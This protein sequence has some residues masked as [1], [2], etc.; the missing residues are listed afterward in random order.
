[1]SNLIYFKRVCFVLG[2]F[3]F[4]FFIAN[5]Q[6][7]ISNNFNAEV[8][9]FANTQQA[10]DLFGS[11]VD[12]SQGNTIVGSRWASAGIASSAGAA[13]IFSQD[14]NGRYKEDARLQPQDIS[15][16]D[17]FGSAVAISGD[18]AVVG[19]YGHDGVFG[20]LKLEDSGA[21]Y[22]YRL[23]ANGNWVLEAK[24]EPQD[25]SAGLGFG[26]AVALEDT[27]QGTTLVIGAAGA[28]GNNTGAFYVYEYDRGAWLEGTRVTPP[29]AQAGDE[30]GSA[31]AISGDALLVA[32]AGADATGT[33]YIY[34]RHKNRNNQGWQV[35]AAL[36]AGDRASRTFFGYSVALDGD[37]ALIGA[38][39][40]DSVA[41]DAGATFVFERQASG[42]WKA[43]GKLLAPDGS[44]DDKFGGAIALENGVAVI[45]A[46]QHDSLATN[47]GAVY[48][49]TRMAEAN[50]QLQ[51][52]VVAVDSRRS[53]HFGS[54][55]A[56]ENGKLAVGAARD[57]DLAETSGSAYVYDVTQGISGQTIQRIADNTYEQP[58]LNSANT[59]S[60]LNTAGF[61]LGNFFSGLRNSDNN[62][63]DGF[64]QGFGNQSQ[65]NQGFGNQSQFNQGF[66]SSGGTTRNLGSNQGFGNQGLNNQGLNNQDF[67]NQGLGLNNQSF[68]NQ[69]FGNQ[70]FDN[71]GFGNQGLGFNN[72]SFDNQ[73]FGNQGFGSQGFGNQGF[74]NQGFESQG[75][76]SQGFDNQGLGNQGLGF[77]NQSFDNQGFG[78]QSFGN[79]QSFGNQSFD[80]QGL[81]NQGFG[82]KQ[83]FGNSQGFANSQGFG[84]QNFTG[85]S[86][87]RRNLGSNQQVGHGLN[88]Q[89]FDSNQGFG[90]QGFGN[91]GFGN[92]GFGNSVNN[93]PSGSNSLFAAPSGFENSG[94]QN[95][96]NTSFNQDSNQ[97]EGFLGLGRL[98]RNPNRPRVEEDST[99][100]LSNITE[101]EAAQNQNSGLVGLGNSIGR[102]LRNLGNG[103][104]QSNN[105]QTAFSNNTRSSN[106]MDLRNQVNRVGDYVELELPR[107]TTQVIYLSSGLPQ[108]L[109]LDTRQGVIFGEIARGAVGDYDVFIQVDDG[110]VQLTEGF[111]WRINR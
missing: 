8:K 20:R 21:V 30:I 97:G 98:F 7:Q 24:L 80:N 15:A 40:D 26:R 47:A 18:I 105:N 100:R 92:Q 23:R 62:Q 2:L 4:V 52:K 104:N 71:Q 44:R 35:E 109:Q 10:F 53:N 63:F 13:Y 42:D 11:A 82:N 38:L 88:N 34:R 72:Q 29:Y 85:N 70:G 45:A 19:A 65:F 48:I 68:D 83:G 69:D 5:A 14:V 41:T 90:N 6:A 76:E 57:S 17:E 99:P 27:V 73:D 66:S 75:F 12:A 28:G 110:Q 106:V 67:G 33:A 87:S 81:N 43:A 54:A 103:F 31:V 3:S 37:I 89:G 107:F 56:L 46:Q 51:D 77:N 74:G 95:Q 61:G 93:N 55:L 84:S 96:N 32:G 49:F 50:W 91:Q 64:N 25:A 111:R 94:S 60:T 102:Q 108:G 1:M 22:V 59:V 78:N 9:L 16:N 101:Q 58:V 86:G 36:S 79:T 39:G